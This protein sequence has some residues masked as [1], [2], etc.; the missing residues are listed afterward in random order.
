SAQRHGPVDPASP[1]PAVHSASGATSMMGIETQ[2]GGTQ[3]SLH[4]FWPIPS[5]PSPATS[6]PNVG[7][8]AA[9]TCDDC[10]GDLP[11]IEGD[12]M[13]IGDGL[14]PACVPCGKNVCEH[15][16]VTNVDG[17]RRCLQCAGRKVW[18]GGQGWMTAPR[19]SVC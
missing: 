8:D 17:Q 10:G 19:V 4:S 15:C 7:Q 11:G 5:A 14:S 13:D 1:S 18:V 6:A 3:R 9:T 16:S 12:A 2:R